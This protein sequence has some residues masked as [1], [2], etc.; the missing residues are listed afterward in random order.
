MSVLY[1]R[2]GPDWPLGSIVVAAPGTPVGIMSLMDPVDA[3][4]PSTPTAAGVPEYTVRCQ[5]I[6]FQA[7][8]ADTHGLVNNTGNIYIVRKGGN[9][10]DP[11]AIVAMLQP[12]QTLFLSSAPAVRD[13]FSPY[14]YFIDADNAADAAQVTLLIF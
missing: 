3:G 2:Q 13:V 11:G 5:Q 14:R 10:D 4:D 12:G 6:M 8:K 9:R 1:D 7:V